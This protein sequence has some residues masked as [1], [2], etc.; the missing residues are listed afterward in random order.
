MNKQDNRNPI[1]IVIEYLKAFFIGFATAA[2]IAIIYFLNNQ[3][4]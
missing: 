1:E 4:K 2:T 3:N